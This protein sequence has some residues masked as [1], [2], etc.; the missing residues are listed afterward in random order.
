LR[1]TDSIV[2]PTIVGTLE[3]RTTS[4]VPQ[5]ISTVQIY[6]VTVDTLKSKVR[7]VPTSVRKVNYE[8]LTTVNDR[9]ISMDLPFI[10]GIR[11]DIPPTSEGLRGNTNHKLEVVVTLGKVQRQFE[12]PVVITT[13]DTLPLYRQFN[14]PISKVVDSKDTHVM[15]DYS[16]PSSAIGPSEDIVMN[17]K[18]CVNSAHSNLIDK[19]R[20]K[21]ITMDIVEIFDC[22]CDKSFIKESVLS[23][24]VK[25]YQSRPIGVRGLNESLNIRLEDTEDKFK[26]FLKHQDKNLLESDPNLKRPRNDLK[27][28][29]IEHMDDPIPLTHHQPMTKRSV[30]FSTYYELR[31]HFK[32]SGAKDVDITQPITI[33]PFDRSRSI[34]LLKWILKESE[35]AESFLQNLEKD[36][37]KIKYDKRYDI[38]AYPQRPPV[39]MRSKEDKHRFV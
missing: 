10:I 36:M 14:E 17:C 3:V 5:P 22:R 25:D 38:L 2:Q 37:G 34:Y 27:P 18:I 8:L 35:M 33:S 21:R 24:I 20:L 26:L 30:L 12:F 19:T 11:N 28:L 16:F 13:Y 7:D 4:E 6:F 31:V 39:K 29:I 32:L 1:S 9:V 23:S 15:I